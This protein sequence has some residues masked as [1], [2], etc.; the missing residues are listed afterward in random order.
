MREVKNPEV[1]KAEIM[2]AAKKL[3]YE[4][5]YIKTTT[6]DIINELKISRG[7]L[8][9]HFDSKEDILYS[10]IEE[11]TKPLL[12]KFSSITND[13]SLTAEEKVKVFIDSTIISESSAQKEDYAVHDAVHLPENTFMM[14]KINHKLSY[15]MAECFS[16]IIKEGNKE[17]IFNV[18]YPEE[19]AAYL[20]TAYT[21][22]ISDKNFHNNELEKANKYLEAFK[23][24]INETLNSQE[25]L[26]D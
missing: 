13:R 15:H 1:R 17:G 18:K 2:K 8:Y 23:L 21:F 16:E 20:M 6:Q 11:H 24:L 19:V 4:K 25:L 3:F 5:G 9:Y 12:A 10:I 14:D 26:F 22:V 7:L